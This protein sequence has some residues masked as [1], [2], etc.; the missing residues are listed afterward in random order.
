MNHR[1][2]VGALVAALMIGA[3]AM[4]LA[5]CGSSDDGGSDTKT[6]STGGAAATASVADAKA[7]VAPFVGRPSPFPVTAP[8][9]RRPVGARVAYVD[10]GT[11]IG[12]L[13]Y[14]LLRPAADAM[15][16]DLYRVKAGS[17]PA[18]INAAYETVA[19]QRPAAV[20][21]SATDPALFGPALAKLK[22]AGVPV[23]SNGVVD[24]DRYGFA[25][26]V[27][28]RE[29]SESSGKLLA[30]YVYAEHG[31]DTDAVFYFMPELGFAPIMKDAFREEM[32]AI[33]PDCSVRDVS[34]PVASLG[35]TMPGKIV[36]DLQ[37]HPD[38]KTV[39][40]PTTEMLTGLP[41]ALKVAGLDVETTGSGGGPANLEMVKAGQQ[42]SGLF[43]DYPVMMWMLADMVARTIT[44]QEITAEQAKGIPP[45]QFLRQE[46]ITFDPSRGWTGYP[47]FAQRFTKLWGAG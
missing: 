36:S 18:T 27:F 20:I 17:S 31:D 33:C 37:A 38:T 34:L 47:D 44:G 1:L 11:P 7:A 4:S 43:V 22:A 35:N 30:D 41:A 5:A 8:L 42:T 45:K 26:G 23:L 16:F 14:E 46:D 2:K 13:L 39:V 32:E 15:G 24:Q 28:G 9:K 19:E 40:V 10:P 25:A 3:S 29:S 12:A 21:D 6:A